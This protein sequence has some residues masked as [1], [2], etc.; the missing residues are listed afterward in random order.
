MTRF[1]LASRPLNTSSFVPSPFLSAKVSAP[2]QTLEGKEE[3]LEL[4]YYSSYHDFWGFVRGKMFLY[5]EVARGEFFWRLY[6]FKI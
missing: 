2:P 1:R 3:A 4:A 6:L 5:T